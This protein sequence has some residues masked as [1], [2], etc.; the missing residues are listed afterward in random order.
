MNIYTHVF[1]DVSASSRGI[2]DIM[3][4]SVVK[5]DSTLPLKKIK[6]A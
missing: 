1:G 2:A 6:N 5:A 3:S 4:A